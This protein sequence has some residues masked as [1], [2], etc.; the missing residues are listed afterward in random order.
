MGFDYIWIDKYCINQN[1]KAEKGGQISQMDSIY[2]NAEATIIAAAGSDSTYGLPGIGHR[3]RQTYPSVTTKDINGVSTLKNPQT[4]IQSSKWSTRG[5]TLQ[6]AVLSRRRLVFTDDQVYF[7]CKAMNCHESL[8]TPLE[9]L[10]VK[11]G[12]KFRNIMQSGIFGRNSTYR[13]SIRPLRPNSYITDF[14]L[15]SLYCDAAT[16]HS[17]RVDL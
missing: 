4:A 8:S 15:L 3:S 11:D 14:E 5:W 6:E 1:N 2:Y 9:K 12:S 16:V 17:Q 7:D 13:S 10:H